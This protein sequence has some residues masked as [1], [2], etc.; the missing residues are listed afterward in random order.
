MASQIA[1]VSSARDIMAT[2][3]IT[4]SAEMDVFVG[5]DLLVRNKISGA[6]VVDKDRKLL[7]VFSEKSCMRVLVDAAYEGLPTNQIG[8]F[9]DDEPT[10]ITPDTQ[11]LTMSLPGDG[12]KKPAEGSG[13]LEKVLTHSALWGLNW[14][15]LM[16]S[17]IPKPCK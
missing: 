12:K 6:P 15:P 17:L 4:L 1:P 3:L 2:R 13:T 11:L 16:K 14:L 5:I 7:G 10:T 9:M 8:K